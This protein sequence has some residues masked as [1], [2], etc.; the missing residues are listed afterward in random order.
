LLTFSYFCIFL[1]GNYTK[2]T[3]NKRGIRHETLRFNKFARHSSFSNFIGDITRKDSARNL[4]LIM[5]I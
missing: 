1:A 5:A 4:V 2:I 3:P